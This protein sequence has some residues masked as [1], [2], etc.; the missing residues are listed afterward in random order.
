M[1]THY[2]DY[3]KKLASLKES[4]IIS[5]EEF[6]KEKQEI[7]R[8][9]DKLPAIFAYVNRFFIPYSN[10]DELKSL[11]DLKESK[12]ITEQEFTETKQRILKISEKQ[13]DLLHPSGKKENDLE[14]QKP[15][16]G[17][18]TQSEILNQ[19]ENLPV[20]S[21]SQ[22]S[23]DKKYFKYIKAINSV[24]I[25][26][27]E[28]FAIGLL[29]IW[30]LISINPNIT[31]NLQSNKYLRPLLSPFFD[32]SARHIPERQE[33]ILIAPASQFSSKKQKEN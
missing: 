18:D 14:K 26:S 8:R 23:S 4:G 9:I 22:L 27:L 6:T 16:K 15:P 7:L 13:K 20:A 33:E 10:L 31:D 29:G 30:Y 28:I 5:E 2:V 17:L 12:V 25:I 19:R 32:S 11:Y 3:L 21:S 24:L 1:A